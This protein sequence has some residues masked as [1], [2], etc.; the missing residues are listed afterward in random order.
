[1]IDTIASMRLVILIVPLAIAASAQPPGTNYDEARVPRYTLPDPL[2][3]AD[4]K[5]VKTP[6]D[7]ALR[8]A[9]L[10]RL[11]E[12]N[13]HGNSPERPKAL[14]SEVLSVDNA[15]LNGAAV[16]KQVR[17][18][19]TDARDRR[20]MDLL[21]YLPAKAA[22]PVPVFLGLNFGGNQTVE[23]DPAIIMTTSWVREGDHRAAEKSRGSSASRWPVAEIVKRG[24][25]VATAYY[26]DIEPDHE[27]GI[28]ES[29]RSAY[30]QGR[31]TWRAI[32]A[33]AWG[34]SRAMD[35]L[36]TD[37]SIDSSRVIVHGHSRLGKAALWAGAT[38]TRFAAVIS[39]NSGEGGA[40]LSRRKFGETVKHLNERFPHWFA[41]NYSKFNGR[42]DDLPVDMHELIALIAPR[43][44]YVASAEKDQWADPRGEFLSAKAADPVYRLL[45]GQGLDAET[46][47]EIEKPVLS[48]IAYHI[49]SGPHDITLYDWTRFLDWADQW[50]ARK[51]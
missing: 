13:I 26:G 14:L 51:K 43:P 37:R 9:E 10:L 28:R 30:P 32:A 42:E 50:V 45:T 12:T 49:R 17:V 4:G 16:R 18:W 2:I 24:Y 34:L 33:W 35:Y 15:A 47:P 11:F 29:V 36:T 8:R 20:R 5:P 27:E 31:Y 7:W 46:L 25:G 1:M 6:R 41:A 39:N 3:F 21:I 23:A 44:V 40:A 19:L 22:G 48:R 38:D